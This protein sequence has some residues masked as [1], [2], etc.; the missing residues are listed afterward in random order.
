[1]S[2]KRWYIDRRVRFFLLIGGLFAALLFLTA[3]VLPLAD[4]AD[5]TFLGEDTYDYAGERVTM[6]GDVNGDG[7][8]DFLIGAYGARIT[9]IQTGG[10][11]FFLGRPAADWGAGFDITQADAS[12]GGEHYLDKAGRDVAGAGDV[13]G[14][15]Y[16][17]FLIGA[18]LHVAS[19][20]VTDTGEVTETGKVYLILG[21]P[22]ANWGRGF[23]LANADAS[24]VGEAA[25]DY[26]GYALAGA[27]DVNGDGYDDFVVGAYENDEGGDRAGKVYLFLGDQD[28]AWGRSVSLA[29]AD[30][31]FIGEIVYSYTGRSVSGAGDVNGDGYDDFLIGAYGFPNDGKAHLILGRV[32]ADWGHGFDLANADAGFR[33]EVDGDRA[34]YAVAG[35]GDVNSDGLDDFLI[36]DHYCD[37]GDADVG[38]VYLILGRTAADW[39]TSF[40]LADADASFWGAHARDYAGAAL[41]AA[42]D[43]NRDGHDDF[44]IG[45][46]GFDATEVLTDSG[47]VYLVSGRPDGWQVDVDL[48]DAETAADIFAFDG[49]AEEDEA[50]TG[51]A[52]G[53][54]VNGDGFADFLV[55]APY[56]DENGTS[57]GKVY[58]ALGKGLVLQKTASSNVVAPGEFINYTMHYT[59]TNVWNVQEV[60]IGDAIPANTTYIGCSGGLNCVRQGPRV[61]W[62]LGSVA[63]QSAGAVQMEV[64]VLPDVSEGTVIL[65]TAWITA[66]SRVNP[67]FSEVTTLVEAG[68]FR[69][70]LPLVLKAYTPEIELAYDNGDMDTNTSWETG[71]GFAVRFT[72][73]AVQAQLMRARYYL[74]DPRPI[75]VHVWDENHTDLIAPF[76]ANTDQDGWNDVDLSAYNVTVSG[77]FYVGFF[78][79]EDYRPTLGI[80]TTSADGRSFE[81][82]GAYW[83]QQISDYMIRAVVVEQ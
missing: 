44:L 67:V 65:N 55:G 46:Y 47:R 24:F 16:D 72:P 29:N 69:V 40:S 21:Q 49:E 10:A 64:Q 13:N 75:K 17:D 80:D 20:T 11:Y 19:G 37:D 15:G 57:A 36:G 51:L 39:G 74:L 26:A 78:H 30:A 28:A 32:D 18:Y 58:L 71:K 60:R 59:N 7:Y 38:K 81:V 33:G 48:A 82:D 41:S 25:Y 23:S 70:Y 73:P 4:Y 2:T 45:A 53:G 1:M 12:F 54:D 62:Y 77:D 83:E 56:N 22:E 66:P 14:D 52:G 79:L 42:G 3:W 5:A 43:V 6:V 8:D 35:A 31:S 63:S 27:G 68:V 34:G 50:G 61:F 9:G 76:T